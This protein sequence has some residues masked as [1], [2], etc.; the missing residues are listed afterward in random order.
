MARKARTTV[1]PYA[2]DPD[3]SV[4]PGKTL[5]ETIDS[6]GMDQRKLATRTGLSPKHINQIV[7]GVAPISHETAIRLER[8]TSVPA[9][10]WNNLETNYREQLAKLSDLTALPY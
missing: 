9:R 3:Y 10:M 7:Q 8:V 2:Y 6:L 5:Q 1:K 4:A